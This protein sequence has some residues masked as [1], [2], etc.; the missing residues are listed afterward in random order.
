MKLSQE[1]DGKRLMLLRSAAEHMSKKF[2]MKVQEVKPEGR[3]LK[4]RL[5]MHFCTCGRFSMPPAAAV[6]LLRKR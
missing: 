6:T 2:T 1:A 5:H 4:K 3:R